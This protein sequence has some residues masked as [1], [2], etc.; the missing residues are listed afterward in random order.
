MPQ[1][2]LDLDGVMA[3]MDGTYEKHW[4]V[5]LNRHMTSDPPNMWENIKS[6]DRFYYHLPLMPDALELWEGVLKLHPNPAILTGVSKFT[7]E[8]DADKRAWVAKYLGAHVPV[9]TSLSKNKRDHGKPGDVLVDDWFKWRSRWEE[10]GGVFI[11][12]TSA[13]DSLTRL[14]PYFTDGETDEKRGAAADVGWADGAGAVHGCR[15]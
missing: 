1:V 4:G 5:R 6:V 10:M 3:D 9:Y 8:A 11:L 12:H 15:S 13:A 7:P 14:Q 2:F